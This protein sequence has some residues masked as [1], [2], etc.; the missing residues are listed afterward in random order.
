MRKIPIENVQ[1][2]G[3]EV[4]LAKNANRPAAFKKALRDFES[5]PDPTHKR[6]DA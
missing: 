5:H 6:S 4:Q 1:L 2:V 3:C